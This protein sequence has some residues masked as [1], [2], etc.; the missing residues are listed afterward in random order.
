MPLLLVV[1][2][3]LLSPTGAL[4]LVFWV[5]VAVVV[6]MLLRAASAVVLLVALAL[7]A[8]VT[9]KLRLTLRTAVLC[10][11]R[12]RRP[13]LAACSTSRGQRF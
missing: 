8:A 1:L 7:V 6:G 3:A 13:S 2:V 12:H 10:P 5:T 4:T 11:S 9:R